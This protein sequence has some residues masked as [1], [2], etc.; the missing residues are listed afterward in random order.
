MESSST[1]GNIRHGKLKS[2]KELKK[3]TDS[4]EY[5]NSDYEGKTKK[6]NVATASK[7]MSMDQNLKAFNDMKNRRKDPKK[8]KAII[9]GSLKSKYGKNEPPMKRERVVEGFKA[10]RNAKMK[11]LLKKT[12]GALGTVASPAVMGLKAIKDFRKKRP[13]FQKGD[14]SGIK[15]KRAGGGMSLGQAKIAAKAPP[16]NK[17]DAK[18]FAV[19]RQEKAR[20]RGMGLQDEKVKPGKVMKAKRGKFFEGYLG[21]FDASAEA[22]TPKAQR[23][24]TTIVGVKPGSKIGK[25]KKKFKSL[26]EMR[27]AKGFLTIDGKQETSSE[28]NKRKMKL[29]GAKQVLKAS[30]IGK[31]ALGIGTAGVAAS[32]YLKSKMNKKKDVKKKMGGGM[33]QR[34]MG[35]KNGT[36]PGAGPLAGIGKAGRKAGRSV[37]S[38][39]GRDLQ[40]RA[41]PE[42]IITKGGAYTYT[43]PKIDEKKGR[44]FRQHKSY[45]ASPRLIS[46]AKGKTFSLRSM[47]TGGMNKPMGYKSGTFVKARGCKLGRTRPTK[48]T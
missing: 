41:K 35:Y 26:E 29:A 37:L 2:Q 3:I 25:G 42:P 11:D 22:S 5:K 7:G 8:E 24:V 4:E 39:V 23:G 33:M 31:I 32:Q 47:N 19:L 10:R 14:Y 30:R 21:T 16:P 17:I 28:F 6:L 20:G 44:H 40:K 1:K 18:D 43:K 12:A 36:K 38:P 13:D 9:Q 15:I 46:E 27:K 34:P 48:I 45:D